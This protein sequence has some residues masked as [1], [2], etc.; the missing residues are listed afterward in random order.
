MAANQRP[1]TVLH[2]TA[3]GHVL[4]VVACGELRP[5][6]EQLTADGR[7]RVRVPDSAKYVDVPA[8][9]LTATRLGVTEDVLDHPLWYAVGT[10]AAPLTLAGEPQIGPS[11]TVVKGTAGKKVVVVWQGDDESFVEAGVLD[12]AGDAP[13]EAPTGAVAKLVAYEDGRLYLDSSI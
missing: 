4:A 8:D 12:S 7:L 9:A 11:V 5:T 3:T 13:N 2:L 1:A 10:G 6:V